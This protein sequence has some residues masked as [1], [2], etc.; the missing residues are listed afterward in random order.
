MAD[1]PYKAP[2]MGHTNKRAKPRPTPE[3]VYEM[4]ERK[5]VQPTRGRGGNANFPSAHANHG[6]LSDGLYAKHIKDTLVAYS[7]TKVKS[8]EE[9][10]ERLRYYFA[11]CAENDIIPTIEEM[12]MFT[13]YD[14]ESVRNWE[15]GRARGFSPETNGIIKKAKNF[16]SV[17]DAKMVVTGKLNPVVYIFRSKNYYGM[18]DQQTITVAPAKSL[19][20]GLTEQEVAER[21]LQDSKNVVDIKPSD[22]GDK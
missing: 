3:E 5:P 7:Q 4:L 19:G 12:F 13:G 9:L 22:S 14:I 17:F 11:Y 10:V 8:D 16:L 21:L 18:S 1:K 2:Q 15:T 6:D 20:D